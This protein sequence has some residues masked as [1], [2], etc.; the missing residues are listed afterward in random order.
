MR[1]LRIVD[2]I[3]LKPRRKTF[4][5]IAFLNKTDAE[6]FLAVHGEQEVPSARYKPRFQAHLHLLGTEVFC[7]PSNRNI[8]E[9]TLRALQYSVE[10]RGG[11][12]TQERDEQPTFQ[13]DIDEFSCGYCSFNED[14]LVFTPEVAWS[15]K[16][17]FTLKGRNFKLTTRDGYL[18][19]IPTSS[20]I[21][22]VHYDDGLLTFI[23]SDVPY[24]FLEHSKAPLTMTLPLL[25]LEKSSITHFRLPA[26]SD[27][28]AT[29]I[30]QCLVYQFRAPAL[31]LIRC[32]MSLKE[33]DLSVFY[34]DLTP[35]QALRSSARG[36]HSDLQTFLDQLSEWTR[37]G[38]LPFGVLYQLQALVYNAYLHPTT[39]QILGSKLCAISQDRRQRGLAPISADAVRT[40]LNTVHWALPF[41]N[42]EVFQPDSLLATLRLDR[43]AKMERTTQ[44]SVSADLSSDHVLIHRVSV[45]PARITFHGPEREPQNRVIRKF[46]R[47]HAYF[48][49]VQFCDE[50]GSDLFFNPKHDYEQI[51]QRFRT[52]LTLGIQIAGRT[53]TFL[54]FSHS[55]LRS[56]SVWFSSPFIDGDGSLQTSSSIIK[57][58]GNFSGIT[59]PARCAARIG[60]AFTETPFTLPVQNVV[61]EYIEDITSS[62]ESRVFSDGIGTI[63]LEVVERI[64]KGIPQKKGTPT[65]FQVRL[66]GA[67]GMLSLDSRLEGS[68]I[69]IRPS[70]V[71]FSTDDMRDL[72]ICGMASEPYPL[73]LNR[74]IVKILE[75]IGVPDDWFF[76]LQNDR[77]RQLQLIS[78]SADKTAT[79]LKDAKIADSIGLYKLFRWCYWMD[80]D[81]REDP[82]LRSIVEAMIL[83]ELR[84]L[85]HKS[86][87]PVPQGMTLYGIIDETGYLKE[88]EVF[89]TFDTISGLY[90]A[91][92]GPGPVL[93][94]RSP[95]LYDGDIQVA[96]NV[97][98]P[99][100]HPLARHKNCIIFSQQG[101]RDLP[102]QLSGGDL[103]GD[104]YHVIWDPIV[105]KVHTSPPANY[106]R[107]VPHDIGRVVTTKDM[108]YF[109]VE[110]MKTD[111][112]GIIATRHMILADQ[113]PEGTH[114]SGCKLLAELHSTAVDYS[115]SGVPVDMAKIPSTGRFRPDFMA[116]GPLAQVYSK[117]KITLTELS[118]HAAYDEDG[119]SHI[120]YYKSDRILGKLYRAID[121]KR[122]WH[123]RIDTGPSPDEDS[124]WARFVSYLTCR[125]S[126]SQPDSCTVDEAL[127]LRS[128]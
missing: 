34:H 49:R 78:S 40:L 13:L 29:I 35:K 39:V 12:S 4:G 6:R 21:A 103:D 68:V 113:E 112:V 126:L 107:V 106:A 11:N 110:F 91:P 87:I 114:A 98:P 97:V 47:H 59:S 125:H 124:F 80:L 102:S 32:M 117:S 25:S 41:D 60:Q 99:P 108:A 94:T 79:F 31:D 115:K 61:V 95:A 109:F 82:F 128:A 38:D 33:S 57:A 85:K 1:E 76:G 120:L 45:S 20:I 36:L 42:P 26:L 27:E 67:K 86:R 89:I 55:S 3:C 8:R 83:R 104:L 64:W 56:H 127:R 81:Y 84:L 52:V 28:H 46:P 30:G 73:V 58:L 9:F 54:G 123:E 121:E 44:K 22:L 23:L 105:A 51:F 90:A 2:F 18:L 53:Y 14:Q 70:M 71:K 17:V 93:V 65:C 19:R 100:D 7:K 48:I 96:R 15:Q 37:K 92:P 5:H 72:G 116:P 111:C 74:Q 16:G 118:S 66:G 62:D 69:R 50:R 24:F 75:D 122:I 63:S 101:A 119:P 43:E 10:Q 77:L 88:N